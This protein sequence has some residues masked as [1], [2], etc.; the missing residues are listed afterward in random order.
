M[1]SS[2]FSKL[3]LNEPAGY[4]EP[5]RVPLLIQ[6]VLLSRHPPSSITL[7]AKMKKNGSVLACSRERN[8]LQLPQPDQHR[9]LML[10]ERQNISHY[11]NTQLNFDLISDTCSF[12]RNFK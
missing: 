1:E 2:G 7:R 10:F 12:V 11:L 4:F 5:F 3:N 6:G 9:S 8:S